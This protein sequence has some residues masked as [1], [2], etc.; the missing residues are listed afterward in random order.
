MG[1]G[2]RVGE[3]IFWIINAIVSF[4]FVRLQSDKEQLC[5]Q[6]TDKFRPPA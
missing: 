4:S 1:L 6:F 2:V 5:D 3:L